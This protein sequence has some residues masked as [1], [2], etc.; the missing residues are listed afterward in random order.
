[1]KTN[2]KRRPWLTALL[3]GLCT[4][5]VLSAAAVFI[6]PLVLERLED[7]PA[8]PVADSHFAPVEPLSK[9][10]PPE[11]GGA[12]IYPVPHR[13]YLAEEDMPG[14][15][16]CAVYSFINQNGEPISGNTYTSYLQMYLSQ[17]KKQLWFVKGELTDEFLDAKGNSVGKLP[18]M[19]ELD[20]PYYYLAIYREHDEPYIWFMDMNYQGMDNGRR[21]LFS[22]KSMK[23]TIFPPAKGSYNS[24]VSIDDNQ[25]LHCEYTQ[26]ASGLELSS[27]WKVMAETGE[28]IEIDLKNYNL[29][30]EDPAYQI[31]NDI[32]DE[33][34]GEGWHEKWGETP[35]NDYT[36]Q[37]DAIQ[38]LQ[39]KGFSIEGYNDDLYYWVRKG[40]AQGYVDKNGDWFYRESVY[41][42]LDD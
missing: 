23:T 3:S 18:N 40:A 29:N 24:I 32:A 35:V 5:A 31:A 9:P 39:F 17:E 27:A 4:V 26:N 19:N 41:K 7:N 16:A 33:L 30:E 2:R 36:N 37:N 15:N 21:G 20:M 8:V 1:M 22:L 28:K 25:V 12:Y 14:Y 42:D 11:G 34:H 6:V 10:M 38:S 13:I